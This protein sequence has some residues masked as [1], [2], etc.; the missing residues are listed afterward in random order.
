MEDKL[1]RYVDGI[2]EDT[3]P[4]KKAA[5][6]KEEMIQNLQDKYKDLVSEGKTPEAAYNIAIAGIGD[7]SGLLE[8]LEQELKSNPWLRYEDKES[9][10]KSAMLTSIA[11]MLYIL[12][13]LPLVILE[14]VGSPAVAIIG[15]P[16]LFIL[17]A[18]ATGL[19][20]YSN[21]TKPK[22]EK[23]SDT[24]VEEFREWKAEN[25]GQKS[26]RRAISSALWTLLVAL[27]FI[28]SFTTG[29][30]HITWIM[31]VLGAAAESFIN[32]FINLRK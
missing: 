32:I 18:A 10:N 19:L 21:M 8:E 1:R 30:W 29:A 28:I 24:M 26:M 16:S 2:F 27:Y 25:K 31:F 3:T 14:V 20:I 22:Y 15:L 9:R 7:V 13:V 4:T 11:V 6:L 5:E 12:S 17:I 23:A